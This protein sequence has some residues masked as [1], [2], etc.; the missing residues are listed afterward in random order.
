MT[1]GPVE[2]NGARPWITRAPV[3]GV[4]KSVD[5]STVA[6]FARPCAYRAVHAVPRMMKK[7]TD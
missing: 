3:D 2:D 5:L 1:C 6:A 4:D 7:R